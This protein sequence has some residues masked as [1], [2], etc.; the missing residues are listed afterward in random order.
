GTASREGKV[1][2]CFSG[3]GAQWA[4]MGSEL[5]GAFPA[6]ARAL[7][8]ACAELDRHLE[9]PLQEL[10]F[11]A[12]GSTEAALLDRTQYTQPALFA[13]EVSLYRLLQAFGVKPDYLIG[14]SIGELSAAHVAGVLS[15][16]DACTLV[17]ARGRLMGALPEAGA[18]A[19]IEASEQELAE[20]LEGFEGR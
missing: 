19:A 15:L 10:L 6:F 3:Q 5:D 4:G 11:A 13:L 8:E 1:A 12:E 17:A 16:Q 2:F 7:G 9:V 20:S 18:M 14:H